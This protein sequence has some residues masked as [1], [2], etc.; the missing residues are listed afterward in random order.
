MFRY[1]Q[2]NQSVLMIGLDFGSTTSR[3]MVA[4]AHLERNP[5]SERMELGEPELLYRSKAILTPFE[6][7]KLCPE[8]I[9]QCIDRWLLESGI[10]TEQLFSGGAIVT[11]LAAEKENAHIIARSVREKVSHAIVATADDPCMES[12]LA[13]MGNSLKLSRANAEVPV[14]NLD[15]GGGTTNPALGIDGNV[16]S[17]GSY[18]I[19]ARHFQFEPGTY[20]LLEISNHGEQL[21]KQLNLVLR[22]GEECSPES[23]ER[24]VS[25]YVQ[26]LEA[27]V[28]GDQGWFDTDVGKPLC[29]VAFQANLPETAS[30]TTSAAIIFSGGVG[31]LLYQYSQT[32]SLPGTTAF[33]DLGVDLCKGIAQSEILSRSVTRFVPEYQGRATV[34]GLALHSAELSG[35]TL[36]MPNPEQLP[37]NDLPIVARLALDADEESITQSI[38]LA[39]KTNSGG[40][41][42]IMLKND[43]YPGFKE[44]KLF[45][46]RFASVLESVNF[47]EAL[48][49]LLLVPKDFGKAIGSYASRWGKLPINLMAVDEVP[50]RKAGFVSLGKVKNFVI[51]VYFYGMH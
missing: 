50:D 1:F 20:R 43:N 32:E 30:R 45:G 25:Y 46:E 51:P 10:D 23:I 28:S 38:Q 3:A 12:W 8:R 48:P 2:G 22:P 4:C 44:L 5:V 13:F 29:Q 35:N 36:Y 11:G 37:V 19:G 24:I 40:C 17:S 42:R 15:I 47:P 31:E 6:H 26:G 14:I 27:I 7:G 9:D 18:Y 33:G 16:L 21:L 34:Y 39:R 49:L 41:I